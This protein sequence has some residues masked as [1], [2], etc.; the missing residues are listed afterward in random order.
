LGRGEVHIG[1]WWGTLRVEGERPLAKPRGRWENNI[2]TV[3]DV[4]CGGTE[5]IH[6]AHPASVNA[7]INLLV[8]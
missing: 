7:V 2:K 4:G 8:P 3:K 6:L 5:W 1:L